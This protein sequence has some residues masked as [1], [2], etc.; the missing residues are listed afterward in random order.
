MQAF[1]FQIY[2]DSL[3]TTAMYCLKATGIG[4]QVTY[5]RNQWRV[6]QTLPHQYFGKMV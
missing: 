3:M 2:M 4:R 5:N 1:G 6:A